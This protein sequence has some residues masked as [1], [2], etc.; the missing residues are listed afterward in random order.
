MAREVAIVTDSTACLPPALAAELEIEIVPVSLAFD[1]VV[2]RDEVDRSEELLQRIAAAK[3]PPTTSAPSPGEYLDAIR[4]ARRGARAVLCITVS[5]RFSTMADSVR[6]ARDQLHA[7]EQ[8]DHVLVLESGNAAM[9][10]G[11]VALAAAEA[12]RGGATLRECVGTA[13]AVSSRTHLVFAL[14]SLRFLAQ[15]GR[16]PHAVAWAAGALGIRPIVHYHAGSVGLAGRARSDEKAL[17]SLLESV[18]RFTG[19]DGGPLHM[20]IQHA[21]AAEHAERLSTLVSERYCPQVLLKAPF[22]PA[23]VAHTGP[24]LCGLAFYREPSSL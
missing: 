4:R 3:R 19:T 20:A 24:G 8:P 11:F 1:G 15:G 14:R 18:G 7:E 9:G 12:A 22:T 17:Q 13:E 21:G 6:A 5:R 23:M 16:V 10:Q 2:V